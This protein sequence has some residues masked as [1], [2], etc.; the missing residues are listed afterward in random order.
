MILTAIALI[1]L[2]SRDQMSEHKVSFGFLVAAAIIAAIIKM[3]GKQG[4][5]Y[6]ADGSVDYARSAPIIRPLTSML[7]VLMIVKFLLFAWICIVVWFRER[8]EA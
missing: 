1:R 6:W 3:L 8:D 4:T 2:L 5:A 7:G